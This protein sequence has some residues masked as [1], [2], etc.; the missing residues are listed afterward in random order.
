MRNRR[1][2]LYVASWALF[3]VGILGAVILATGV[4]PPSLL[5][6]V[7]LVVAIAAGERIE[8]RFTFDRAT[9]ALTLVEAAIAAGL[10]LT[11]PTEA[12]VATGLGMLGGQTLRRLDLVKTSF[13]TAQAMVGT[14]AAA[15]IL[16]LAPPI[17]PLV[18]DLPV[19]A[20]I[21]GMIAYVGVNAVAMLGLVTITDGPLGR[22]GLL[23]QLPLLGTIA[24]GNTAIGVVLAA[25]LIVQPALAPLFL[26]PLAA[27]YFAAHGV[28][29]TSDLLERV[30]TDRD[31]LTRVI[32]GT[33]DGIVLLDRDGTIQ[34][35]NAAMEELT[36]LT[37]DRV[38]NRPVERVLTPSLR[39]GDSEVSGRWLIDEAHEG[40]QH[41]EFDAR[42]R[43]VDGRAHEVREN[44]SLL[45]DDRGR[46]IGD[47][48][49][50]RDVTKQRELERLRG[51]FVARVSHELRTPLT[52]IR[53]FA[54]VLLRKGDQLDVSS[55]QEALERIV[56]RSDHLAAVVEDLLLVTRLDQQEIDDLVHPVPTDLEPVLEELI[57]TFAEREPTR[58]I[59]FS[60]EPGTG[61]AL[62]DPARARQIVAA[63]LDN[64]CRY[65]PQDAPVEVTLDQTGDDIR[66]RV[67]DSGPG[68]PREHRQSIFEQF[69]R[70]E[71]P[72]TMR[73]GGV[74]LGLF[75]GRRLAQA[76]HG[77]L[78]LELTKPATGSRFVL[79]L[80]AAIPVT[81]VR[82]QD[83]TG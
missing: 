33:A 25:L 39:E 7:I 42:I 76:M 6:L 3:A 79:R 60:A 68:V 12:V 13:N 28:Q 61:A 58:T 67:I 31:R 9:I 19:F 45:F 8:L 80:P 41:R 32:D 37:A 5:H 4:E 48:V 73:T 17:G 49:V 64:A 57:E 47:V 29:R 26:V 52:P 27:I 82:R 20:V 43:H 22:E 36:G 65:S 24:L 66:V 14:A 78:D 23:R 62:A 34:V 35:W 46:C 40:A 77:E 83:L 15:T 50:V 18:N 55:R 21:A 71:D 10:L 44:H 69:H 74:G 72:L 54:S 56:E 70:L 11:S 2:E 63:L 51:D 75:I 81:R 1:I 38:V 59:L 16:H 30:R 53:G